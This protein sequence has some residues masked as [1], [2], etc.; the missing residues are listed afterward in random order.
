MARFGP[1]LEDGSL[2]ELPGESYSVILLGP[3][4]EF[5]RRWLAERAESDPETLEPVFAEA[6]WRALR[7]KQH[8]LA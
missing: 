5:A 6:A 8:S 4:Q 7:G 3:V 2:R 1:F